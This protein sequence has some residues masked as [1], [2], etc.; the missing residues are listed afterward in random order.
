MFDIGWGELIVIG[1]VA[2]I[3]IGPK[4]LP[5][6]LRTVGQWMGKVRRMASE[7]QGQFQEAM[8]E[9]EFAELKKQVDSIG[10]GSTFNPLETARRELEGA[11]ADKPATDAAAATPAPAPAPDY[12]S[13][14]VAAPAAA[15]PQDAAAAEPPPAP[16]AAVEPQPSP[17]EPAPA[18]SEEHFTPDQPG[19]PDVQRG[20]GRAA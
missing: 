10:E 1:V 18:A 19:P 17:P 7:F 13:A 9:A 14:D 8:R 5:T 15:A 12:T 4:E 16:P 3:A 20:G 6:V 11:M 2:L